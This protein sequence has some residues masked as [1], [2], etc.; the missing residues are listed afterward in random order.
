M[1]SQEH[2]EEENHPIYGV[3]ML[4]KSRDPSTVP[5]TDKAGLLCPDLNSPPAALLS[6][7]ISIP[8]HF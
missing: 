2:W 6:G 1:Q 4:G 8:I 3:D 7:A 5:S